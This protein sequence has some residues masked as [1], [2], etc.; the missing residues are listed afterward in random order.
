MASS[1]KESKKLPEPQN[2]IKLVGVTLRKKLDNFLGRRPHRSFRRT[3]ARDYKRSLQL[4]GY[5]S[6]SLYVIR[7]I[8]TNK[9]LF[10]VLTLFYVAAAALLVGVASQDTY[11]QLSSLLDATGSDVLTGSWGSV[12]QAGLLLITT[13]SGSLSPSF[14]EAQQIYS[15]L[16]LLLI[17]L[18]VVYTLR[19]QLAGN[20]P[21]LREVLYNSGAPIVSTGIVL[22]IAVIQLVPVALAIVV[23]NAA[24]STDMFNSPTM[25]L[26]VSIVVGGLGLVSV[27]WITSTL[28][29]TVVVTLPGMYPWQAIR[30]AGDLVIGRR[31]R[32]L[33]RLL[34]AM[35]AS[36]L[37]SLIIL[38][39]AIMIDRAVKQVAPVVEWVPFVP[40]I[41]AVVSSMVIV[42]IASYIYLLYRKV[43]EDDAN[44]A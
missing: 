32:I 33:L 31:V 5:F 20:R 44:P 17:W 41:M 21:K 29:A 24:A 39:P 6:F 23:V 10:G 19:A 14:T 15:A 8:M 37:F 40:L 26:I 11:S 16:L 34:W 30:T 4:P 9:R 43:V 13:L 7:T 2:R 36:L 38:L 3:L 25:S 18:A 35:V 22:F 28:I 42:W 12:G 27:Y 1:K